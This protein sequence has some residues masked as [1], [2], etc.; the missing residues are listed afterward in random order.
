MSREVHV[1]FWE[2]A[3]MKLRRATHLPFYRQSQI[4]ARDGVDLD[5]ATPADWGGAVS[6]PLAPLLGAT[7][8]PAAAI[9]SAA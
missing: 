3:V 2:R 8:A 9:K 6:A 7:A 1:R 4:Y 5:R